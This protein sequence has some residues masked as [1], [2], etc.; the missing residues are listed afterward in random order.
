ML[1]VLR[2]TAEAAVNGKGRSAS[3]IATGAALVTGAVAL[4]AII[5]ATHA[6][7]PANPR[8]KAD[9][10]K[11]KQPSFKPP[12]KTFAAVWP[13]MFLLL[14]VSGLRIWNAPSSP[15]RSRALGLWGAVQ[16]LNALWMALGSNRLPA[17]TA[18]AVVTLGTSVAYAHEAAKVDKL[19]SELVTP[20]LGWITFANLLTGEVLRLNRRKFQPAYSVH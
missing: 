5:A 9:Y 3:H 4:S 14:T 13:P 15:E 12:E 10:D 18:T 2:N 11:L 17:Q 1:A 16:G 6:P 8:I 20:F 7:T 19:S